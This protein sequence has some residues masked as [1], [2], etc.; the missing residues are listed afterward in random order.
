M[1]MA[2]IRYLLLWLVTNVRPLSL[3]SPSASTGAEKEEEEDDDMDLEEEETTNNEVSMR[4]EMAEDDG[5]QAWT[6]V[7]LDKGSDEEEEVVRKFFNI[8]DNG[9]DFL[10]L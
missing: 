9:K 2:Q 6:N 4:E 1:L 7:N 3:S 5:V 8:K 10:K